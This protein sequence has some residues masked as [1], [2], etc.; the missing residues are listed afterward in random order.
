MSAEQATNPPTP[1]SG[2]SRRLRRAAA[3]T[4]AGSLLLVLGMVLLCYFYY[5]AG[6]GKEQPIPFSHRVHA[7]DKEI[8]CLMCHTT[9]TGGARAGIPPLETCMLCHRRIIITYPKVK[10]LREH[11]FAG[12]PVPWVRVNDLPDYVY[13]DHS[14]HLLRGFDCGKCH[15]DVRGMD[16]IVQPQEFKMGYCVQCH[17]DN[18]ASH[19]CTICHR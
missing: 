12:R 16:R 17:R 1:R 5:P 11:Y 4:G 2:P 10:E 3:W 18:G 14:M 8:S 7:G 19:D 15:G 13:F 6:L 9:A